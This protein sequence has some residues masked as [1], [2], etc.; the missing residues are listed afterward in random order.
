MCL[1]CVSGGSHPGKNT[2][3][4]CLRRYRGLRSNGYGVMEEVVPYLPFQLNM[5]FREFVS[6]GIPP[7]QEGSM[8]SGVTGGCNNI[9]LV[10]T[11]KLISSAY[12]RECGHKELKFSVVKI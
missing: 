3:Y 2:F 1:K 5:T 6:E 9:F 7:D 12:K 10:V 11:A 8:D 4:C